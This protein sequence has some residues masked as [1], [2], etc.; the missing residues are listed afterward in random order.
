[1]VATGATRAL[2]AAIRRAARWLLGE[3]LPPPPARHARLGDGPGWRAMAYL[4]L[5]LPAGLADWYAVV[6]FWVAG[7]VNLTYP[8]WWRSFR[9]HSPGVQLSPVP[10]ITPF[11]WFGTAATSGSRPSP[12]RSPRSA[13]ARP[14]CWPPRG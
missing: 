13:R 9:N 14:C 8:F 2:A 6:I 5:K 12:A 11:G 4:L 10:V 3:Q 1:M 7:L